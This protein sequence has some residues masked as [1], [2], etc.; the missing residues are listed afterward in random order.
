MYASHV[1]PVW[2]HWIVQRTP[3]MVAAARFAHPAVVEL[4]LKGKADVNAKDRVSA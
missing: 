4:L 3:L 2:S 1:W